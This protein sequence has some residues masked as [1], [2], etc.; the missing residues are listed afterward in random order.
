MNKEG[1]LISFPPFFFFFPFISSSFSLLVGSISPYLFFCSHFSCLWFIG[2]LHTIHYGGVMFL[3]YL[4]K[5]F[6]SLPFFF[7]NDF[8]KIGSKVQYFC[9]Q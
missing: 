7:T 8:S 9:S 1:A 5:S 6:F 4:G 2:L 3:G